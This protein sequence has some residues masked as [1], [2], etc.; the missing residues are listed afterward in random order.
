MID[1]GVWVEDEKAWW[2]RHQGWRFG[3]AHKEDAVDWFGEARLRKL[4]EKGYRLVPK[5]AAIIEPSQSDMQVFY[6]PVEKK[7][8]GKEQTLA[9]GR[10]AEA[11]AAAEGWD[12]EAQRSLGIWTMAGVCRDAPANWPFDKGLLARYLRELK[13]YQQPGESVREAW[14]RYAKQVKFRKRRRNPL[15]DFDLDD[16]LDDDY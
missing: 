4:A 11:D 1:F 13:Q 5:E 15:H 14:D 12:R 10:Q 16:D 3:F 7:L 2:A 9:L 6:L 8:S